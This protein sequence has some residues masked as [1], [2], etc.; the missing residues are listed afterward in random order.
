M[1]QKVKSFL[2]KNTSIRQTI[3]KNTFWLTVSQVGGRL[4]RAVIII[5]AARVLGAA[6][7]GIFSYA[8]TLA[9]LLTIFTDFG[10]SSI[11]SREVAKSKGTGAGLRVFS[12]AFFIKSAF[13]L[14]AALFIVF[15]GPFVTNITEAKSL[16][17]IIALI[18]IFDS[19]REFGLAFSRAIERM[20]LEAGLYLLTNLFVVVAGIAFLYLAPTAKSLS[21]SYALGTG[22][23]MVATFLVLRPHFKNILSNFTGALVKPIL[24]SGFPFA[25]AGVLGG[26]MINTDLIIIGFFR[27][28]E[29]L[30]FYGVAIRL[31]QFLYLFP[32]LLSGS[33]FPAFA[34]LAVRDNEKMRALLERTLTLTLLV[35]FPIAVGGLIVAPEII[36]FLFGKGYLAAIPALRILMLTLATTFP[37][38]LLGNA[39]FAYDKQKLLVA[40]AAI[41]GVANV[42]LDLL[43]IPPFGILGSAW[44]TLISQ[45]LAGAYLWRAAKRINAFEVLSRLPRVL[46]GT[47]GMGAVTFLLHRLGANLLLTI[48]ASAAVYAGLLLLFRE[49]LFRELKL[50]LQP[51]VSGEQ[52]KR[53]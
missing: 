5:Y 2:F 17:P 32:T 12:T 3:A 33:T 28:A 25:I 30:G 37:I 15:G 9:A 41:G 48:G 11:V 27:S 24:A 49:P 23:G 20:E 31:V 26:L 1:L 34:R 52:G 16:F 53:G 50:T 14:V 36:E 39:V 10:V 43:F 47:I 21:V 38:A 7:Y 8:L 46:W 6:E 35:A 13:L 4:L 42:I 44:A 19:L 45:I 29:E 18:L 40:Y 22:A 51:L